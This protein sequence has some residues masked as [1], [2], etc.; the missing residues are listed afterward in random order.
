MKEISPRDVEYN[1]TMLRPRIE[2][3][4]QMTWGWSLWFGLGHRNSLIKLMRLVR[5]L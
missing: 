3:G 2:A 4:K 5:G 1:K